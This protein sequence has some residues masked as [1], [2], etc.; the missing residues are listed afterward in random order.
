VCFAN[1]GEEDGDWRTVVSALH[2]AIWAVEKF[3]QNFL[4]ISPI[5]GHPI[6]HRNGIVQ[7]FGLL[8]T[9]LVEG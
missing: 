5:A 6:K 9:T 7:N 8:I 2:K 3:I 1:S 4:D